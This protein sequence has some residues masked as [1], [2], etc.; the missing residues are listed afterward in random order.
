MNEI[1]N[2]ASVLWGAL[3]AVAFVVSVIVQLT[4]NFIPIPTKAWVI[5]VSFITVFMVLLSVISL[6]VVRI[7]IANACFALFGSFLVAYIAMYG[8][9]TF[10]ELWDRLSN[11]GGG[12]D[13]K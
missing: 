2:N 6:G 4:K 13:G 10:K 9:D 1:V 3:I 8:F 12:I 11:G 5:F 7:T